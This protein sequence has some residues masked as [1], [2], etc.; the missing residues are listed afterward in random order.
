MDEWFSFLPYSHD[1]NVFAGYGNTYSD[2]L[3]TFMGTFCGLMIE[4]LTRVSS[5]PIWGDAIGIIIGC[6]IGIVVPKAIMGTS[7]ETLGLNKVSSN[8]A[9]LGDLDE[10]QLDALIDGKNTVLQF[11][12]KCSFRKLDIDNSGT[13]DLGE[14]KQ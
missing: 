12:A 6:L 7:S 4:D 13:L 3:G 14:I 11:R 10:F 2:L 8:A 9:F 5:T 1:A